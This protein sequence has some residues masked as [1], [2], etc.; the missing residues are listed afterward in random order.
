[1]LSGQQGLWWIVEFLFVFLLWKS[2]NRLTL[3]LVL[4]LF[5]FAQEHYALRFSDFLTGF[6]PGTHPS[7]PGMAFLEL[8]G[9][10]IDKT[11]TIKGSAPT[12]FEKR[13]ARRLVHNPNDDLS[14]YH[15]YQLLRGFAHPDQV[16]IY[17]YQ[18]NEGLLCQYQSLPLCQ[19]FQ[20][21]PVGRAGKNMIGEVMSEMKLFCLCNFYH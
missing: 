18:A 3:R 12:L 5:S 11:N 1:V 2:T 6:Y 19:G 14:P 13:K 8:K 10:V 17:C 20:M 7:M 21:N 16:Y 9:S 4:V 15:L